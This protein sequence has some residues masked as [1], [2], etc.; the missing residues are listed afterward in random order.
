[1]KRQYH[2]QFSGSFFSFLPHYMNGLYLDIGGNGNFAF[3]GLHLWYVLVLLTFSLLTLPLFRF[4]GQMKLKTTYYW[5]LPLPLMLLSNSNIVNLGSWDILYYLVIFVYGYYFFH[6]DYF[7]EMIHKSILIHVLIAFSTSVAY[8]VWFI[9]Y[10]SEA[11]TTIF[12]LFKSIC[13]LS[14]WSLLMI[15]FYFGNRY[16]T[17]SHSTLTYTSDAA[18]PFY[19]LHQPVIV[20]IGFFIKD[21][22]WALEVKLAFLIIVC[23]IIVSLLYHFSIRPFNLVRFVFGLK[24]KKLFITKRSELSKVYNSR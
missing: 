15:M 1:M 24:R 11:E 18:M 7:Y 12:F 14:C 21:L 2:N 6:G 4:L 19:I 5:L 8:I 3:V 22:S 23:F 20:I 13:A 9:F 16:L 10:M 17:R